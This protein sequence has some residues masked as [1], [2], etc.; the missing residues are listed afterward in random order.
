MVTCLYKPSDVFFFFFMV[1][2]FL[3]RICS[4]YDAQSCAVSLFLDV[5]CVFFWW[6]F[7]WHIFAPFYS[8]LSSIWNRPGLGRSW[9]VVQTS[10]W[11]Q[12]QFGGQRQAEFH[13][14]THTDAEQ[15]SEGS[16]CTYKIIEF[17]DFI[18]LVNLKCLNIYNPTPTPHPLNKKVLGG[19][20]DGMHDLLFGDINLGMT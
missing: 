2:L 19:R 12:V 8:M 15:R 6:S 5:F 9:R 20:G 18:C 1:V 13:R 10:G 4:I 16:E 14:T 3:T 7:S 11:N 17:M